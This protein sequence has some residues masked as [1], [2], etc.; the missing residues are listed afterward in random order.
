MKFSQLAF[1]GVAS[2][3]LA[4]RPTNTTICDYYSSS[5]LGANTAANQKLLTTLLINTVV[6]GNYTTPNTGISVH[7]FA[8]PAIYNGTEVALLPY[9][10]PAPPSA[11]KGGDVGVGVA[12]LD[13][14]GAVP[15]QHNMS[16]NGNTSSLQ[17]NTVTHIYEYFGALLNCS[18][19]GSPDFPS[20]QGRT[21]MYEVHKFMDLS[22][23]AM[24][25]FIK[26]CI[27]SALSLGFSPS[28]ANDFYLTL[29]QFNSR[30][31]PPAT[32][33]NIPSPGKETKEL[34]SVC[35]APDCKQDPKAECGL[36]AVAFE[37]ANATL[38][39]LGNGT[40]GT[41]TGGGNGTEVDNLVVKF[42]VS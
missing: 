18:L 4:Q 24:D 8:T 37:P 11:N 32:V 27:D 39:A 1:L 23:F 3:S 42:V 34:Q 31:S 12:F 35:L 7:G 36:Y 41:E 17:Y 13:D 10:T 21:S 5:I 22:S 16:S 40:N 28:D 9:F 19:Q 20:Y 15:L 33:L 6:L 26:Q 38:L 14:G 25:F 29:Q 30:C 2:F